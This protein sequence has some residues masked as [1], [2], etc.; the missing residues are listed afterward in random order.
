MQLTC[1]YDS[2]LGGI[3]LASDGEALTGLWFDGQKYFADTLKADRANRVRAGDGPAGTDGLGAG[4]GSPVF[5]D[6]RRWLDVY[7]SGR[8]PGFTPALHMLTTPFRRAVWEV[9]LAIPYG[10][11]MTYGEIA[12]EVAQRRGLARMS[13]QAVGGAVGQLDLAHHP[14]PPGCRVRREPDRL[15][16]RR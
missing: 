2:P 12:A 9:M 8:D 14:V 4:S 16:G 15:R 11:T 13:A 3:L 7:F 5:D 10:S 6:A 1:H